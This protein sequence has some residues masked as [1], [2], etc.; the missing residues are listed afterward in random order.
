MKLLQEE[1]NLMTRKHHEQLLKAKNEKFGPSSSKKSI[2]SRISSKNNNRS[3]KSSQL[4]MTM[5]DGVYMPSLGGNTLGRKNVSGNK[6]R[7]QTQIPSTT[8]NKLFSLKTKED[9]E[10]M[11]NIDELDSEEL[12]I[13]LLEFIKKNDKLEKSLSVLKQEMNSKINLLQHKSENELTKKYN[14]GI[15]PDSSFS[16]N[17]RE[18]EGGNLY[19]EQKLKQM[20]QDN[21]EAYQRISILETELKNQENFFRNKL[22]NQ[23]NQG[24]K[25]QEES[26]MNEGKLVGLMDK[27]N[28][29]QSQIYADKKRQQVKIKDTVEAAQQKVLVKH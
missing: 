23:S 1:I 4:N 7:R 19:Y 6:L 29:E 24:T 16:R 11:N 22:K 27:L 5:D 25:F 13:Q 10:I 28:H 26:I 21:E 17:S 9:R 12:R 20:S 2:I 14:G 15:R 8:N 3:K 18:N